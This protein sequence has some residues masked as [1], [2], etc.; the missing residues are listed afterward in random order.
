MVA[1][2][3]GLIIGLGLL[4]FGAMGFLSAGWALYGFFQWRKGMSSAQNEEEFN[5]NN[6]VAAFTAVLSF[7]ALTKLG[8]EGVA[9]IIAGEGFAF[10]FGLI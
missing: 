10:L 6:A 4:S 9:L 5:Q 2:I 7:L 8:G 3:F 1:A